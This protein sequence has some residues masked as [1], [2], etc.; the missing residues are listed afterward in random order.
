M[1]LVV[2]NATIN[3][4]GSMD[5]QGVSDTTLTVDVSTDSTL[6]FQSLMDAVNANEQILIET[7]MNDTLNWTQSQWLTWQNDTITTFN[8]TLDLALDVLAERIVSSKDIQSTVSILNSTVIEQLIEKSS[9]LDNLRS[10]LNS[11]VSIGSVVDLSGLSLDIDGMEK[12]FANVYANITIPTGDD[13]MKLDQSRDAVIDAINDMFKNASVNLAQ[14]KILWNSTNSSSG[15]VVSLNSSPSSTNSQNLSHHMV[16]S[17]AVTSLKP[18][19]VVLGC[20]AA[21]MYCLILIFHHTH[22]QCTS[23]LRATAYWDSME[24]NDF[25]MEQYRLK[26]PYITLITD[27]TFSH[28]ALNWFKLSWFRVYWVVEYFLLKLPYLCF[29]MVLIGVMI[30]SVDKTQNLEVSPNVDTILQV[31]N[32]NMT[33]PEINYSP[34]GVGPVDE[35]RTVVSSL[36]VNLTSGIEQVFKENNITGVL[37]LQPRQWTML[38]PISHEH[39]SNL[40]WEGFIKLNITQVVGAGGSVQDIIKSASVTTVDRIQKMVLSTLKTVLV[41]FGAVSVGIVLVGVVYAFIL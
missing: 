29:I 36:Q 28:A 25:N 35:L 30:M 34:L 9:Q 31:T 27:C 8:A 32:Y 15:S 18:T 2:Y 39:M 40:H 10:E 6:D 24:K 16:T 12:I 1:S 5:F 19:L 33:L 37:D 17:M 4:V 11:T 3:I 22:F 23:K 13:L 41:S 38:A 14:W 26:T 21:G 20:C 7:W